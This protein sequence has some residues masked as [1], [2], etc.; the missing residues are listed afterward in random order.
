MEKQSLGSTIAA[1]R[2]GRRMTQRELAEHLSVSDK[3]VSKWERGESLPD[4]TLLPPL[5]EA[6]GVSVDTLLAGTYGDLLDDRPVSL[7]KYLMGE[8]GYFVPDRHPKKEELVLLLDAPELDEA[9]HGVAASA[10]TGVALG[11]WLYGEECSLWEL[12]DER[13]GIRYISNVPLHNLD[14]RLGAIVGELEYTRL[15]ARHFDPLLLD[16]FVCKV[17]D[18]LE[19]EAVRAIALTREITKR[20]FFAVLG[21]LSPYDLDRLRRRVEEGS[22]RFFYIGNP[23]LWSKRE[24]KFDLFALQERERLLAFL[25]DGRKASFS[26]EDT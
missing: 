23:S 21:R 24:T 12:S 9:A 1:L 26:K 5:A 10:G 18:A 7:E 17:R 19:N 3:T 4:V 20:Y 22:L 14:P 8:Y 2:H 15:N 16:R 6:L 25:S 11:L 13:I